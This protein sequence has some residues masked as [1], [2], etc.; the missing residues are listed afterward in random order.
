MKPFL[1]ALS[2]PGGHIVLVHFGDTNCEVLCELTIVKTGEKGPVLLGVGETETIE[3][4]YSC[5]LSGSK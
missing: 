3:A 4:F 1:E 5:V 2:L